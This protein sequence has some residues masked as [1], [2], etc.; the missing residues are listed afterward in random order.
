MKGRMKSK[1]DEEYSTHE[2]ESREDRLA[3]L[4]LAYSPRGD[5]HSTRLA[6]RPSLLL[7]GLPHFSNNL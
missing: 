1:G 7:R 5:A 6:T 4:R 2:G 3:A